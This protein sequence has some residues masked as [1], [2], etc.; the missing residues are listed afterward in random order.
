MYVST[1]YIKQWLPGSENN[2]IGTQA[3]SNRGMRNKS[4]SGFKSRERTQSGQESLFR[5]SIMYIAFYRRVRERR[6]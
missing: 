2:N 6:I 1:K 4:K 3:R 5:V